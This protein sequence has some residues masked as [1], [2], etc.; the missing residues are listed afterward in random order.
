MLGQDPSRLFASPFKWPMQLFQ[1]QAA[2]TFDCFPCVK[3]HKQKWL[4][5][6]H[7]EKNV[8]IW[9]LR[10]R[11]L[12]RKWE[13]L[14]ERQKTDVNMNLATDPGYALLL[15]LWHVGTPATSLRPWTGKAKEDGWMDCLSLN[16]Q[17]N[18]QCSLYSAL[19]ISI[20]VRLVLLLT[21]AMWTLSY[22]RSIVVCC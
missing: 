2:S 13:Q 17:Y 6:N 3:L 9:T 10:K 18:L 22:E 21:L 1:K 8:L 19:I 15:A 12:F 11:D 4:A 20:F 16:W 7:M 5:V 14:K